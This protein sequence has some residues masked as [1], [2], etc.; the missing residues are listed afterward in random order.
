MDSFL[1]FMM[2]RSLLFLHLTALFTV[3]AGKLLHGQYAQLRLG[4]MNI[5][6]ISGKPLLEADTL[7]LINAFDSLVIKIKVISMKNTL[8]STALNAN[9]TRNMA[10]S[11]NVLSVFF[12]NDPNSTAY[13]LDEKTGTIDIDPVMNPVASKAQHC[14]SYLTAFDFCP[15]LKNNVMLMKVGFVGYED[16]LG[17]FNVT[18]AASIIRKAT[19][20]GL[21][22][23]TLDV[24]VG[25]PSALND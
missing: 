25:K 15:L 20:R 9:L 10:S 14:A 16:P 12:S 13:T 24:Q 11:K 19:L 6:G 3:D 2:S 7:S 21:F 22:G 8:P 1:S 18:S 23:T 5:A 4:S 17:I